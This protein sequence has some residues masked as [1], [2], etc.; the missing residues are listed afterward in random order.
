[1]TPILDVARR[2]G[3]AIMPWGKYK[4]VRIRLIPD[5]YLSWLTTLPQM[6]VPEWKWLYTSVLAELRSRDLRADL[7]STVDDF[8]EPDSLP[9]L[10][11]GKRAFANAQTSPAV[12]RDGSDSSILERPQRGTNQSDA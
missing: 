6:R 1:M 2:H 5:H 9:A 8:A 10:P 12:R 11:S 3:H 4:G 7:A